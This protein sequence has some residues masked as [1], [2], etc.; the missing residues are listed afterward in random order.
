MS[1]CFQ[2]ASCIN[3]RVVSLALTTRRFVSPE[4][5]RAVLTWPFLEW[6]FASI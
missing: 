3:V 1:L 2:V 5:A 6:P 4:S